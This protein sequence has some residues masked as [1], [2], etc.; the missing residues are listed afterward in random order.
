V[1]SADG[2]AAHPKERLEIVGGGAV[3][4]LDDFREL[5]V[6]H[7][8]RRERTR[9]WRRDK[10]HGAELA[11]TVEAVRS[12]N[13]EP[14]PFADVVAGMRALFALRRSLGTGM[15]VDVPDE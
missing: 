14:I 13:P 10:G 5:V 12:G 6:T 1:Y 15:P 4:V 7:R 3:A 8:G 2:D 9:A 11:A